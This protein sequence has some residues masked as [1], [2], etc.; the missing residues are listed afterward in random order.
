M[1]GN[2]QI[3]L[4][5]VLPWAVIGALAGAEQVLGEDELVLELLVAPVRAEPALADRAHPHR[6]QRDPQVVGEE[7]LDAEEGLRE[8]LVTSAIDAVPQQCLRVP[9]P[10]FV[11][12]A[13]AIFS[14]GYS[15]SWSR[16]ARKAS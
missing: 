5:P 1:F 2:L 4:S 9:G 15:K 11:T 14:A 16:P 3:E 12:P 7:R 13:A 6:L 8:T 10:T